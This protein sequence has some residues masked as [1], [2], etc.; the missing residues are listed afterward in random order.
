[1]KLLIDF[2]N[3]RCKWATLD[4]GQLQTGPAIS[5]NGKNA[6]TLVEDIVAALPLQALQ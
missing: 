5:Y 6:N 4:N 3:S 2:G 1:M